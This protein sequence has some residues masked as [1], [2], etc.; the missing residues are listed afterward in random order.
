MIRL[1]KENIDALNERFAGFQDPPHMYL[2]VGTI[3]NIFRLYVSKE[4]TEHISNLNINRNIPSSQRS[5]MTWKRRS[6]N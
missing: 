6:K 5:Y 3:P 4:I 2:Q 1:T